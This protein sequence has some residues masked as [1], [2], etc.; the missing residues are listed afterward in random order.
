MSGP[1]PALYWFRVRVVNRGGQARLSNPL[2]HQNFLTP[3]TSLEHVRPSLQRT[4]WTRP[5]RFGT[6]AT[7]LEMIPVASVVFSFTNTGKLQLHTHH[8]PFNC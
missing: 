3:C 5:L 8:S 6:V 1:F 2:A 7:L 4:D